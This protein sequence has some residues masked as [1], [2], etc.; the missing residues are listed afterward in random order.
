MGRACIT[1]RF[2]RDKGRR[3]DVP[4]PK[5]VLIWLDLRNL[6]GR[7]RNLYEE[8]GVV[9]KVEQDCRQRCR[10]LTPARVVLLH[11]RVVSHPFDRDTSVGARQLVRHPIERIVRFE[12]RVVLDDGQQ[13]LQRR[14]LLIGST[15]RFPRRARA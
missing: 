4:S 9:L 8:E 6:T 3:T 5:A 12:L 10:A 1:G 15:D 7:H 11:A 13:P 2:R 14:R